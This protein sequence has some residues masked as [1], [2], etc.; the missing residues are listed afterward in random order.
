M[1]TCPKTTSE[2]GGNK[3]Y[4][5]ILMTAS[6]EKKKRNFLFKVEQNCKYIT[7]DHAITSTYYIG[8]ASTQKGGHRLHQTRDHTSID[9]MSE[10]KTATPMLVSS[11]ISD[12]ATVQQE[13]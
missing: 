9:V 10:T 5:Y 1:D 8:Q 13:I 12:A 11:A 6:A 2:D 7:S 3:T 4:Y